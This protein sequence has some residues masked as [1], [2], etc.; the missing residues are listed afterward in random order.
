QV[1]RRQRKSA[2]ADAVGGT[3]EIR[4]VVARHL[5]V[6][7]DQKM[8]ELPPAGAGLSKQFRD[9]RLQ[10]IL[11]E[12]EGRLERYLRGAAAGAGGRRL[13]EVG[14]LIEEPLRVA[15]KHLGQELEHFA[16][17]RALAALDH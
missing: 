1:L 11:G 13:L 10:D 2:F 16:R 12:E 9:R 4:E 3:L 17:G 7:A 6:G 8:R 5:L 15:L 14:A